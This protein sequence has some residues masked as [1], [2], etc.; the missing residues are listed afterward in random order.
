MKKKRQVILIFGKTGSGKSY[1]TKQLLS[2]F[3]RVIVFDPKEEYSGFTV[4][5]FAEFVVY[6]EMEPQGRG[7][8]MIVCRFRDMED[9]QRAAT[10]CFTLEDLV[11]VLEECELFLSSYDQDSDEPINKI[12]S[13]GRHARL[14]VIALGRRPSEIPIRIRAQ[15]STI[16]TFKQTERADLYQLASWG[17]DAEEVRELSFDGHEYLI[18]GDNIEVT[19]S[20][21]DT[22]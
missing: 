16:V 6:F 12:I 10:A 19:P 17:F 8:F 9:Y 5:S 11:L 2:Q 14:S 20:A 22:A 7:D 3:N 4:H 13:T 1:L 18:E 21:Q 15:C